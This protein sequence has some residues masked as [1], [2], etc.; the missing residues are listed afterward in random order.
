MLSDG[1]SSYNPRV[2]DLWSL[3]APAVC[4]LAVAC[5][6]SGGAT[7]S[8]PDS[9][10]WYPPATPRHPERLSLLSPD[11]TDSRLW[12]LANIYQPLPPDCYDT[13]EQQQFCAELV[14]E[15]N[16]VR[17]EQGLARL[18]VLGLLERVAQAH[19]RDMAVRDYWAHRTP[20]GLHSW[21]RVAAVGGGTVVA[22]GENSAINTLGGGT[23]K[24]VIESWL[25]SPGHRKILL[26][27][28]ARFA[29]AGTYNFS[30]A[31]FSRYVMLIVDLEPA[32]SG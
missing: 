1:A 30:P 7:I 22:G 23:P 2:R 3:L 27:P 12:W 9:G 19:A 13:P 11:E 16:R 6:G 24:R 21:D 14:D 28:E 26:D 10:P 17:A 31:E 32:P 18:T 25:R 20:E 29:G 8:I 15:A 4:L 5:G